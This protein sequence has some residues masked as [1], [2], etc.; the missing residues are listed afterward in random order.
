MVMV[1]YE[2]NQTNRLEVNKQHAVASLGR[3]LET[4]EEKILREHQMDAFGALRDFFAKGETAGY[5]NLPTASGKT[6]LAGEITQVL[7]LRTVI[8]S[9]TRPIL[10][11]THGKFQKYYPDV[12]ISNYYTGQK[13]TSGYVLNTTYQ[14]FITLIEDGKINPEEIDLLICDEA[15]TALGEIRH[16]IFKGFTNALMIGLTATPYFHQLEGYKVRGLVDTGEKW[17]DLFSKCI[18]EMSLEEAIERGISPELDVHLIRTNVAVPEIDIKAGKYNRTQLERALNTVTRNS[19]VLAMVLGPDSFS[20]KGSPNKATLS[21]TQREEIRIIHEK[22]KGKKTAIFGLSVAQIK[23]LAGQL[24]RAGIKA[25]AVYG[26]LSD[27]ERDKI[28]EDYEEG[29][30]QVILGVDLLRLGWDSPSTEVGIFMEPHQSGVVAVQELGR[31]MR[32]FEGIDK[33]IVIQLLDQFIKSG[34]SPVLIPNIFDP[35]YV[36][37][38][39]QTG[40][41]K[42]RREHDLSPALPRIAFSGIEIESIIEE[43][44][45][46]YLLQTRLKKAT[47]SEISESLDTIIMDI[48]EKQPDLT[49]FG[50]YQAIVNQL[51]YFVPAEKQIEALQ[52]L[53]SIDTNMVALGKKVLTLLNLKSIFSAIEPFLGEDPDENNEII[54]TAITAVS[55]RLTS[56]R[57]N[58]TIP[59]SIFYDAR[60][61]VEQ[62][63]AAREGFPVGWVQAGFRKALSLATGEDHLDFSYIPS[64]AEINNL[65]L[66]IHQDT[67]IPE[68]D[69]HEVL[70]SMVLQNF[71]AEELEDEP[72]E[73]VFR[74]HLEDA[75]EDGLKSELTEREKK[76]LE[77]RW[78]LF[79]CLDHTYD[80]IGDKLEISRERVRQTVSEAIRKLR[81]STFFMRAMMPYLDYSSEQLGFPVQVPENQKQPAETKK[82]S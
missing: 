12:D 82:N 52:A 11:Q 17:L 53:A 18:H 35:Y 76:V 1:E 44:Q 81:T 22:I 14:S 59:Q 74:N 61:R 50:F 5:I 73:E 31:L 16:K 55:E 71:Q 24:S 20:D 34:Q 75:L 38:G 66:E 67:G 65:A 68:G 48:Y 2:T 9:P 79:G 63:I 43:I 29:L 6:I 13:D 41:E 32:T 15:H 10:R 78:G 25:I 64:Q 23:D 62:Y 28:L 39:T 42:L 60:F 51:P 58:R 21:S 45:S 36:L 80:E 26:Q 77:M 40:R 8:L 7:G 46:R 72:I 27:K 69:I 30:Y 49:T 56:L 3:F 70:R 37:R 57:P 4:P 19:L 54:Q 47:L 33:K